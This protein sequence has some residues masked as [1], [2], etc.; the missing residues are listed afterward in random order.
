MHVYTAFDNDDCHFPFIH[1]K[2]SVFPK[3]CEAEAGL[4]GLPRFIFPITVE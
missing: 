1:L 3:F 4:R 2:Y